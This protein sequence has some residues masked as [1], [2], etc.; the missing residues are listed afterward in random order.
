MQTMHH[1]P[2]YQYPCHNITVSAAVYHD[3]ANKDNQWVLQLILSNAASLSTK[4]GNAATFPVK[5]HTLIEA[6]SVDSDQADIIRWQPHGRA[7]K[8]LD[9]DRLV[10]QVLP[11]YLQTQKKFSSFQRQLNMYGFHK[12][13]GDHHDHGAYYHELFLRG[14]P[15]LSRLI[16]R[17]EKSESNVRRKFDVTSEPDFCQLPPMST[18][19]PSTNHN[20]NSTIVPP[21]LSP[22]PR[23]ASSHPELLDILPGQLP[24]LVCTTGTT[25]SQPQ[26]YCDSNIALPTS[27]SVPTDRTRAF[28]AWPEKRAYSATFD[29]IHFSKRPCQQPVTIATATFGSGHAR[30]VEAGRKAAILPPGASNHMVN[31]I[32]HIGHSSAHAT[33]GRP[34]AGAAVGI[35]SMN[36]SGGLCNVSNGTFSSWEFDLHGTFGNQATTTAPLFRDSTITSSRLLELHHHYTSESATLHPHV[37]LIPTAHVTMPPSAKAPVAFMKE[38][39]HIEPQPRTK[40]DCESNMDNADHSMANDALLNASLD[41]SHDCASLYAASDDESVGGKDWDFSM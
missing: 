4:V 22:P 38:L 21:P 3:H 14:R 34:S 1:R 41:L 7:F 25:M 19:S 40:A 9:R 16:V 12:L 27:T 35:R 6:T 37:P 13:T 11:N 23:Q 5:L 15:A 17:P 31:R 33:Q 20:G 32:S 2:Q 10:S 24:L 26:S 28:N 8:F 30:N 18:V 36:D 39:R 29:G